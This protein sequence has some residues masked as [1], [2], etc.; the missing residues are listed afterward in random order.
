MCIFFPSTVQ[1][2]NNKNIKYTETLTK[3]LSNSNL[4]LY[5]TLHTELY[6]ILQS[7]TT[8]VH[9]F[10]NP[11]FLIL[12][13]KASLFTSL[14]SSAG[15]CRGFTT[16]FS[17]HTVLGYSSYS[18]PFTSSFPQNL[19]QPFFPKCVGNFLRVSSPLFQPVK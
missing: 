3:A 1:Y 13:Q 4:T 11:C 10:T 15:R 7:P 2:I 9:I 8:V 12:D 16:S 6:A 19:L 17:C 5:S 14:Y 18:I